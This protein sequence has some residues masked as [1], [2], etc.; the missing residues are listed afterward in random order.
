TAPGPRESPVSRPL[1]KQNQ[2]C[3]SLGQADETPV[4]GAVGQPDR[5]GRSPE[6][7]DE[8][9]FALSDRQQDQ[10]PPAARQSDPAVLPVPGPQSGPRPCRPVQGDAPYDA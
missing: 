4:P 5:Q 7:P 3:H 6:G 9:V 1:E 2:R 10:R 8:P